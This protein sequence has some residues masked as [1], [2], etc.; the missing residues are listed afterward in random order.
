MIEYFSGRLVLTQTR[1]IFRCFFFF[2]ILLRCVPLAHAWV[3][4]HIGLHFEHDSF[5]FG[6]GG[7]GGGEVVE[8]LKLGREEPQQ[9]RTSGGTPVYDASLHR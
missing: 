4:L 5:F 9:R 2:E 6:G 3:C 1:P 8:L 7:G